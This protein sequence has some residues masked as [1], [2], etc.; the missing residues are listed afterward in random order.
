MRV[1]FSI[2]LEA[3]PVTAMTLSHKTECRF[4]SRRHHFERHRTS[5]PNLRDSHPKP[6]SKRDQEE[7]ARPSHQPVSLQSQ[8]AS[9]RAE[10]STA[11]SRTHMLGTTLASLTRVGA[12]MRGSPL[13]RAAA[14]STAS[15]GSGSAVP[16]ST[17]TPTA[18]SATANLQPN[19]ETQKKFYLLRL[20]YV[21]NFMEARGPFRAEHL[22]LAREL[23]AK[24]SI[25]MFG[26]LADPADTGVLV[27]HTA[28]RREIHDFVAR[29]SYV[30]NN[31]VL[32]HSIREW[33]VV[34]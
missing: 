34:D 30:R 3:P 32:S 29:D 31:L 26:A 27:F 25:V 24:G 1:R 22:A 13:L 9:S 4:K 33:T 21:P 18:S 14:L 2:A 8:S 5:N 6:Q 11:I 12:A 7:L 16:S 17:T 28:D 19:Q 23:R 20:D 15:T 10:H